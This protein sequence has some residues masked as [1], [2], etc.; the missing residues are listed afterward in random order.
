MFLGWRLFSQKMRPIDQKKGSSTFGTKTIR[1]EMFALHTYTTADKNIHM[2]LALLNR[3]A[4]FIERFA[5]QPLECNLVHYTRQWIGYQ[6][7]QTTFQLLTRTK[8]HQ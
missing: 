1:G 6:A 5:I 2:K 3:T 8:T 7:D 4:F